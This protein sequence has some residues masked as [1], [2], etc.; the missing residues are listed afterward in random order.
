MERVTGVGGAFRFGSAVDPE[1]NRFEH[2]E[3]ARSHRRQAEA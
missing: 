3:P 1:G 2:W